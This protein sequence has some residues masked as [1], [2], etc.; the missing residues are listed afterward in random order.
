MQGGCEYI[1]LYIHGVRAIT[2]RVRGRYYSNFERV[3]FNTYDLN[4][5]SQKLENVCCG[6]WSYNPHGG[7]VWGVVV[8]LE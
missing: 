8:G 4:A 3:I 5:Q 2:P 6:G 1:L 7:C